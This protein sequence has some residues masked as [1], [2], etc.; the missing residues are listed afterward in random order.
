LTTT[1]RDPGKPAA[2]AKLNSAQRAKTGEFQGRPLPKGRLEAAF[3]LGQFARPRYRLPSP[4]SW[5]W[6]ETM[7]TTV[8]PAQ[9]Y[10]QRAADLRERSERAASNVARRVFAQAARS[11][12]D[13]ADRCDAEIAAE[14]ARAA[15]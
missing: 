10:R 15:A 8:N 14:R 1:R 3:D 12:E 13:I 5:D 9:L 2:Y 7:N 4:H 11:W 6:N